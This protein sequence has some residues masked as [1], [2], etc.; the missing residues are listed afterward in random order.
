[1]VAQYQQMMQRRQG[2]ARHGYKNLEKAGPD[3]SRIG[4]VAAFRSLTDLDLGSFR[5][6]LG[7]GDNQASDLVKLTFLGSQRWGP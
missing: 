3:P 1:V 2:V 6:R 4:A 5:L 7:P